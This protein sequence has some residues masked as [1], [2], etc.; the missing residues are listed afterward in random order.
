MRAQPTFSDLEM[1]SAGRRTRRQEFLERFDELAP[2]D[3][4]VPLAESVR[5]DN[6]GKRGRPTCGAQVLLRMYLVSLLFGLS[7]VA[8]EDA[9]RDSRAISAFVGCGE[10]VPD[11]TTLCLFRRDAEAAGLG[12][13]MLDELNASLA[14]RGLS[15]SGGTIVDATFVEAPSSTKN[16]RRA[17]DPEAHQAKKGNNWHFGYKAHVGVDAETG[18]PHTVVVTA[19]NVADVA[20]ARALVRPGDTDAWADAGYTGVAGRPEVAGDPALAGVEWR[21][22][23]RRSRISEADRPAQ[24]AL[25]SVRS[26]VEHTFHVLKDL[27]GIRR[28]RLRGLAANENMLCAA[29]AA[30]GALISGRGPRVQGPP[31]VLADPA[32]PRSSLLSLL[33]ARASA[34]PA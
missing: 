28:T 6:A 19:A 12:C 21:V 26:V 30:A 29:L 5:P 25:A 17:R 27:F 33:R 9:C 15:L 14:E 7:D 4:W 16:A 18:V 34:L 23:M 24:R 22:A 1:A 2:W 8:C 31:A 11:S 13:A 20:V 10:A 3:R 32:G